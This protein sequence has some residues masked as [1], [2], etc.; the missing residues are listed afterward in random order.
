MN[1]QE[2]LD[3]SLLF[4]LRKAAITAS[5]TQFFFKFFKKYCSVAK[6]KI[7]KKYPKHRDEFKNPEN[8]PIISKEQFFDSQVR[9][10]K[11]PKVVRIR[12]EH[13]EN[14]HLKNIV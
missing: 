11:D 13:F 2:I 1:F 4:H 8:S 14:P 5:C 10:L 6:K 3:F 9:H 12:E 7:Y